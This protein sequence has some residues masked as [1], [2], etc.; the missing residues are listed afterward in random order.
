MILRSFPL[1]YDFIK[2]CSAAIL[3]KIIF[4]PTK[5]IWSKHRRAKKEVNESNQILCKY[6]LNQWLE[7]NEILMIR[8]F[9][10]Y[11]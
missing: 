6:K 7:N 5:K 10:K 9:L 8:I 4:N 3:D 2:P 11:F 1:Q